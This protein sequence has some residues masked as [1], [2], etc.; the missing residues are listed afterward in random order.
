MRI[1][2]CVCLHID[3][4]VAVAASSYLS[5]ADHT[6]AGNIYFTLRRYAMRQVPLL[7]HLTRSAGVRR[8]YT[9]TD[10]MLAVHA[11]NLECVCVCSAKT[12]T[13]KLERERTATH[14]DMRVESV[15]LDTFASLA[16]K[17]AQT[18]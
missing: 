8:V 12:A 15:N 13:A 7:P 17:H 18:L 1:D 11:L 9:Q 4:S 5:R 10:N 2:V 16:R 6:T 14:F 3:A